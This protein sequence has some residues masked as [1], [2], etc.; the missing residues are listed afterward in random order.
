MPN[1]AKTADGREVLRDYTPLI[2]VNESNKRGKLTR[3]SAFVENSTVGNKLL[4][5]V[6][7][8]DGAVSIWEG[9]NQQFSRGIVH[10]DYSTFSFDL[11]LNVEF[12]KSL[13]V[14]VS[15]T[16]PGMTYAVQGSVDYILYQ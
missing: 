4:F 12:K 1:V 5:I 6:V 2:V 10:N 3:V 8:V 16:N 13:E 11:F 7:Y 14:R 15:H 9:S